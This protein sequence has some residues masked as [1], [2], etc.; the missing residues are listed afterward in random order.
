MH[1]SKSHVSTGCRFML[2]AQQLVFA[3]GPG[4]E[5]RSHQQ[6]LGVPQVITEG[7]VCP[8]RADLES[9]PVPDKRGLHAQGACRRAPGGRCAEGGAV[10]PHGGE[11]APPPREGTAGAAAA[12]RGGEEAEGRRQWER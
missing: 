7:L 1:T 8:A 11:V 4:V 3:Q 10:G 5:A 9:Q 12:G 6:L 2:D